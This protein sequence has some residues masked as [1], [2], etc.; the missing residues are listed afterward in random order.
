MKRND[1]VKTLI[2]MLSTVIAT[3]GLA[4]LLN[5][6]TGPIIEANK[7]GAENEALNA[8]MPGATGF[9]EITSTLTIDPSTGVT[10][11]YKEKG[12]NGYVFKATK[13]GFS[14]P[15]NVV[16]GV[17]AN[18]VITGIT[19]EIGEGDFPVNDMI[20]TFV[21]QDSTLAGVILQTGATSSSKAVKAAVEA[22]FLVLSS[23]NLMQAAAKS[24][25]QVFEELLPTVFSGAV[26]GSD[27]TPS[28]NITTAYT[29]LTGT[30]IVCYVTKGDVKLLA[31]AN[32]S[33]VVTVYQP[34]LLDE[35]TQSYEL[36]NV[37]EANSDVVTEVNALATSSLTSSATALA[38]KIGR[39]YEGATEI[40]EITVN[41]YGSIAAAASFTYEGA[42]YYGYLAKSINAYNN[43]VVTNYIV[44]DGEGKV[45]KF[46]LISYFGD[47]EY[48]GVAHGF[49][50]NA[51]ENKFVGASDST[52]DTNNELIISGATMTTNAVKEAM[53]DAFKAFAS[54]GGNN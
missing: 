28:G 1:L 37:T 39:M 48:F 9:E 13:D 51:Y 45:A 7:A 12:G 36:E 47:E 33:G 31:I 21:G 18:G 20:P 53:K 16:V 24:P 26:K 35:A 54:K 50:V 40:T 17:D 3:V 32:M 14:K 25:E 29:T 19:V 2:I 30:G 52:I 11:V 42:T 46:D 38:D 34:K 43:S 22:G 27:L 23:N 15:V 49:D 44:L 4:L 8:V 6:H 10:N 41:T 5:L